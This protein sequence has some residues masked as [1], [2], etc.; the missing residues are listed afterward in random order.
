VNN[1]NDKLTFRDFPTF[2]WIIGILFLVIA[3][4]YLSELSGSAGSENLIIEVIELGFGLY[5]L[6]SGVILTISADRATQ[7]LTVSNRS[8]IKTTRLQIPF[9]EIAAIQLELN[10]ASG[11]R[12]RSRG[13]ASRIVAIRKDGQ[14]VPFEPYYSPGTATKSQRVEKLRS[15]LGVGGEALEAGGALQDYSTMTGQQYKAEQETITGAEAEQHTTDGVTWTLETRAFGG[16][17]VT[18]WRSQDFKWEG[19]FLY[20]VQKAEGQT[21]SGGL[22]AALG[23]SVLK[24]SM[25]LYG[26]S[27][28]L[29]PN[30]HHAEAL[31]PLDSQLEKDFSALTSDPAGARRILNPWVA[32]PLAA[33]ARSHPAS[34]NNPQG[35]L[36]VLF[37]PDGVY[38][39]SMGL[40]N[41]EYLDELARLGA[42]LVK[43]QAGSTTSLPAAG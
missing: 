4:P 26:F 21:A 16:M 39:A 40:T 2:N 37:S 12:S 33:W 30:D 34:K 24:S 9:A 7:M 18:R 41:P 25:A 5:L 13:P 42:E 29:T 14:S 28:S 35:Q 27:G 32:A 8:L 10:S 22:R 3:A 43:T 6:L 36:A 38:L 11:R 19:Q 1:P 20:L 15:F 17:P 31:S 23:K